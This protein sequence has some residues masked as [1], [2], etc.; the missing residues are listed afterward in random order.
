[1]KHNVLM[2]MVVCAGFGAAFS[3]SAATIKK[4]QDDE[5]KWHYGDQAAE[6]C[7]SSRITEIN[8]RGLMVEEIL[9]VEE[10]AAAR[11]VQEADKNKKLLAREQRAKD[12]Q[13]LAQ[14]ES[15]QAI[16]YSRDQRLSSID[17]YI[18]IHK[19][20]LERLVVNLA[21]ME[22]DAGASPTKREKKQIASQKSQIADYEAAIAAREVD[23]AKE[24]TRFE[25]LLVS[26]REAIKRSGGTE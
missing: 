18:A 2:I 7:A 23:R 15:E 19:E 26:Y 24:T 25:S 1:M 12:R 11:K 10:L 14:Y 17:N 5:G 21:R 13:M 22:K 4:C 8:D 6:V 9:S 20:L 3:V 16:V